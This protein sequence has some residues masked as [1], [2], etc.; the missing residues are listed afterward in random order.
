MNN[1][2][3]GFFRFFNG[4]AGFGEDYSQ[5]GQSSQYQQGQYNQQQN[6]QQNNPQY[7]GGESNQGLNLLALQAL[8]GAINQGNGINLSQLGNLGGLASL[9]NLGGLTSLFSGTTQRPPTNFPSYASNTQNY[10]SDAQQSS[11]SSTNSFTDIVSNLLTG[12]VGNRF[13]RSSSKKISKRSIDNIRPKEV[14][15]QPRIINLKEDIVAETKFFPDSQQTLVRA[16]KYINQSPSVQQELEKPLKFPKQDDAYKEIPVKSLLAFPEENISFAQLKKEHRTAVTTLAFPQNFPQED[17]FKV[18]H[19]IKSIISPSDVAKR[20]T[21]IFDDRTGTGNLKFDS[22]EFHKDLYKQKQIDQ[23]DQ[24]K[25]LSNL[26]TAIRLARILTGNNQ[27]P[28][29]SNQ[30]AQYYQNQNYNQ[31][32]NQNRPIY[33]ASQQAQQNYSPNRYS[34]SNYNTQQKPSNSNSHLVYVTGNTGQIEYVLDE[35][36]G[37]KNRY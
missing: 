34:A 4:G 21:E 11:P 1:H 31:N 10:A 22:D 6:I 15:I 37:Q 24:L 32:Y 30:N 29:N 8:A 28:Q 2:R 26:M 16:P 18:Q 14:E 13:S 17:T 27:K 33:Q 23:I 35:K 5:Q 25:Q 3:G 36:T 9:G 19:N 7:T 20:L 12:I